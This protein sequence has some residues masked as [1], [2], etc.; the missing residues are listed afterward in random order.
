VRA[1]VVCGGAAALSTD[2]NADADGAVV[3]IRDERAGERG[4][5]DGDMRVG[6]R[7]DVM[8]DRADARADA[9]D[10][11]RGG[12]DRTADAAFVTTVGLDTL[13]EA[14]AKPRHAVNH[15][16]GAATRDNGTQATQR[17]GR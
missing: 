5:V 17:G 13:S 16:H 15:A 9:A 11:T 10:C 3:C 2:A 4:T 8:G 14:A 12:G 7:L 6:V 1:G